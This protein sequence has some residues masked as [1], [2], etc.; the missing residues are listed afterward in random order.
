[1]CL[2]ACYKKKI[3]K[4]KFFFAFL[5]SVKKGVGSISERYGSGDPDPH[6]H[7]TQ[8]LN[9]AKNSMSNLNGDAPLGRPPSEAAI[10]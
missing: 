8:I 9:T 10:R 2:L 1:M 6:Q 4:Q 3:G 7:V 5:N